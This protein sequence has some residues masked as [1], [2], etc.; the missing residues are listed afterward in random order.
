MQRATEGQLLFGPLC[1]PVGMGDIR[2]PLGIAFW[3]S[4]AA[5][6][7]SPRPALTVAPGTVHPGDVVL[8]TLVALD[9]GASV[10]PKGMFGGRPLAFVRHG[11]HFEAFAPLPL[12]VAVGPLALEATWDVPSGPE[13]L[14]GSVDVA[15]PDFPAKELNVAPKFL[16]PPESAKHQMAEDK[17]AFA[18]AFA[19]PLVAREFSEPFTW[20]RPPN[21]NAPFGDRRLFNGHQQSQHYGMDLSGRVGDSVVA[22]NAGTVVMARS[23]YASGNTVL[24]HHG[25]G[26]YTAYFHLSKIEV[27]TGERIKR[28]QLLGRVGK[29]G[30]VTGPHL[31][32][33]AKVDG[34]YVDPASLLRLALPA[35]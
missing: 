35:A 9:G 33:G 28:G 4:L 2:L 18:D 5:S 32:F 31:H 10:T 24:L 8:V 7:A 14:T 20:P 29:T 25:A 34:L 16:E 27:K 26:V 22:A 12:E 17:A 15:A 6:A 3:F 1:H 23:C 30:R 13:S 19:Q 21:I 11:R